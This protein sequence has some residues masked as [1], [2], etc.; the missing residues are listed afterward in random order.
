MAKPKPLRSILEDTLKSLRIDAPMKGYSLWGAWGEIVG[1][2][3]ASNAQP[4]AVRNRILFVEVSHPAW[5]QQLQFLKTALL[6]K[7]NGFL[8][9]SLIQDI[10][11]R[12]GKISPPS[13]SPKESGWKEEDLD[14]ESIERIET[15]L[16]AVEDDEV[17]E[18]L[19]EIMVKGAKLEQYR[20]K[21]K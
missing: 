6:E 20:K 15:L 17:R 9:E 18:T 1:D 4:S 7:I 16:Q 2:A 3:V 21:T 19:R 11:F 13:A 5:I 10:R 12:I 8:G 14:R